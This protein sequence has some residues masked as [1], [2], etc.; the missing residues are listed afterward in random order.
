MLHYSDGYVEQKKDAYIAVREAVIRG[1]SLRDSD[2]L[3]KRDQTCRGFLI[4]AGMAMFFFDEERMV[5]L[6]GMVLLFVSFGHIE[7]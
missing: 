3:S 7:R 1:R 2:L 5:P 6:V 4:R